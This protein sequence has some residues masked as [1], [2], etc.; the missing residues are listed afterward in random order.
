[1]AEKLPKYTW[2]ATTLT[3]TGTKKVVYSTVTGKVVG[4]IRNGKFVQTVDEI[5]QPSVKEPRKVTVPPSAIAG[6]VE[7]TIAAF[8]R[9]ANFYKSVAEDINKSTSE[10]SDARN[11]YNKIQGELAKLRGKQEEYAQAEKEKTTA[12]KKQTARKDF[13]ALKSEYQTLKQK[14]DALLDKTNDPKAMQYKKRMNEIINKSLGLYEEFTGEASTVADVTKALEGGIPAR[15]GNVPTGTMAAGPTG[16]AIPQGSQKPTTT[17][18]SGRPSVTGT[19]PTMPSGAPAGGVVSSSFNPAAFRA[20][21]EASMGGGT[22]STTATATP[23][24]T[25][26]QTL[27]KKTEFWYDLPDYVFETVPELGDLLVKAVSENWNTD[28]FLSA[29]KLTKW[30]QSNGEIFR[31][32]IVDKAKYNELRS[33]GVDVSKTDY[34]QYI[35]KQIRNVKAQAKTVAGVT[36]DDAQAQLIAEKIYDGNLDD[37]PLAINRLIIPYIGKVT[38]RYAGSDITTYGGQALQNYQM[39]QAIAKSNGLTIRDILPQISTTTTGGDLEK[40]V[41]QALAAGDIDINRVAQNARMVAAQGQPEYVRNLLNQ[42][43][44]LE[45]VYAPYKNTMA[46]VLELNPDQINLNDPTLRSAINN[47]GDMNI[48]DFKKALRK[49]SRWQYTSNAREEVSNSALQ[50]LRDFGFQ[51]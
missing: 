10:R 38:D 2:S 23:T 51:G 7:N 36:L 9:D 8:E 31:T 35:A 26:L 12:K 6:G 40:A 33:Q 45:Q 39:L 49:D 44:D 16:T 30:W 18:T 34:G 20:G 46:V 32:R 13:D 22:A 43:Y 29:A 21:E 4:E 28:K 37:D 5:P 17:T 25:G 50:V 14:F 42:G 48:Y 47:N 24:L 15:T 19:M 27:L 3:L 41:L 11:E 1:M